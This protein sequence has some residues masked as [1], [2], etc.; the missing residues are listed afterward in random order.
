MP[1]ASCYCL[2]LYIPGT[3]VGGGSPYPLL[4]IYLFIASEL[5]NQNLH[6]NKISRKFICPLKF[7]K[8]WH[9]YGSFELHLIP[10]RWNF[11][12][13]Y[14]YVL[15][16]LLSL[17]L[18][19]RIL[20]LREVQLF[21]IMQTVN[22]GARFRAWPSWLQSTCPKLP[23]HTTY[24]VWLIDSVEQNLMNEASRLEMQG[25]V[26]VRVSFLRGEDQSLFYFGLQLIG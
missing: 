13:N 19:N 18:Q 9:W 26:P 5:L 23:G 14:R 22:G 8:H 20:K 12:N 15:L 1:D 21:K 24:S 3:W 6:S 2:L 11:L 10:C 4:F 16:I 17:L 25:R 7:Q